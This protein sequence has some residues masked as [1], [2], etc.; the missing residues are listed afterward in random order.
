[1]N[2]LTIGVTA[3]FAIFMIIGAVRGFVRSALG[4][5][6]SIVAIVAAY[7]LVPVTADVITN[8]T[9]ID[10]KI[11]AKIN[12]RIES[13]IEDRVKKEVE[14][15]GNGIIP[16]DDGIINELKNEVL[17]TEPDKNQQIDIINNLGISDTL[18][19]ALIENNNM[20]IKNEMGVNGFYNY[21][22]RYLTNRI[23]NLIAYITTFAFIGLI[24]TLLIYVSKLVV[25]LPVVNSLNRIGGAAFGL[26]EAV[27]IIWILFV[28]VD[29]LPDYPI[30]ISI[31]NQIKESGLLTFIYEKNILL[32][33]FEELKK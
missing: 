29:N 6:L 18:K 31:N 10:E 4:I 16:L 14:D 33:L 28:I 12:A 21:I 19:N 9:S 25:R 5:I 1:M 17:N 23:I 30:C 13:E 26:M 8:H 22:T 24:F 32:H 27:I 3:F 15:M 2:S 7:L 20:E 11:E